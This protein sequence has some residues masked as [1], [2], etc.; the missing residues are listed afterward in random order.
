MPNNYNDE[1]PTQPARPNGP[2]QGTPGQQ[3]KLVLGSFRDQPQK[4]PRTPYQ[5]T[6][7]QQ[8]SPASLQ[9]TQYPQRP[10]ETP[11][12][13][14]P[15]QVPA[16]TAYP[17]VNR[18]Y[19]PGAGSPP[20]IGRRRVRKRTIGC[21]TAVVLVVLVGAGLV[22]VFQHVMAFGS[23]ISTQS[24]LSTQTGYMSGSDRTNV[25]IMG[26]GG[27]SHDGA[28]LTDSLQVISL[29]PQSH[30]TSQIS[31]PRDLWVQN[32]PNSGQYS[33]I[34]AV[35]ATA[36]AQGKTPAQAADIAA[37]KISL[38]TGMPVKYWVTINFTGFKDL[39]DSIGGVDVDV[40]DSF[41]ACY[42]K[43][44]DAAVDA[45]WI[46]VQFTKGTQHMDGATAIEYARAREPLAVCGMGTSE[47]LAELTDFG[48]AAR[49]QIIM[50]A[51]EDK[52]KQPSTWPNIYGAMN[53]LQHTVYTN[54]SLADLGEFVM[55]MDLNDPHT[56]K[57]V[58]Q[59]VVTDVIE[60]DGE[61]ALSPPNN[62]WSTITKYIQQNLY[63]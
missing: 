20:P 36:I 9:P 59:N 8:Q 49:Q 15:A 23:A 32:P 47:N 27:G 37:Q 44:D 30:H 12:Q 56:A 29:M 33:K 25:L 17:N 11:W 41:N 4:P 21:L 42:P 26:Y 62:D 45:S 28:N 6:P 22:N 1:G 10:P 19:Q 24:P 14:A 57:I 3:D 48:R 58:L 63:Q 55:H 60:P 2:Y 35:Y 52:F 46:K 18:P 7:V 61:D 38:V 50:K 40:P 5:Y 34:N 54:M 13:H 51:V 53:A 31:V 39:I 43:N 16:P